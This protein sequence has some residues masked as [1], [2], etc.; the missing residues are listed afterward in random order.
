MS[1][2]KKPIDYALEKAKKFHLNG[3]FVEED[4]CYKKIHSSY[5]NDYNLLNK[6]L[7]FQMTMSLWKP[8]LETISI[9]KKII[10]PSVTVT[11]TLETGVDVVTNLIRNEAFVNGNLKNYSL[12]IELLKT[13]LGRDNTDS[14]FYDDLVKNYNDSGS[15]D[16]GIDYFH[17]ELLSD[18]TNPNIYYSLASLYYYKLA[19]SGSMDNFDSILKYSELGE[20][21]DPFNSSNLNVLG[22]SYHLVGN[23]DK[24]E[25]YF[26]EAIKADPKSF[27]PHNNLA[28]LYARNLIDQS[29]DESKVKHEYTPANSTVMEKALYHANA[30]LKIDPKNEATLSMMGNFLLNSKHYSK[31]I[32]FFKSN[33]GWSSQL[34]LVKCYYL[35]EDYDNFYLALNKASSMPE[36][37]ESRELSALLSHANIHLSSSNDNF[38]CPEPLD[39][40]HYLD[41]PSLDNNPN[42]N[43]RLLVVLNSMDQG[44][45]TQDL[46]SN[47]EQSTIN[48]F[49]SDSEL[50]E[51]FKNFLLKAAIEYRNKYKNC[52]V[53]FIKRWPK[54]FSMDGWVVNMEKGGSLKAHNH[55]NGWLSGV[56]YL[57]VPKKNNKNEGNIN[58]SLLDRDYPQSDATF[59]SLLI[60]T[61]DS[62]LVLFP[63]SLYHET[64]PFF[65]DSKRICIAFDFQPV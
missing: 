9:I 49:N 2:Q 6:L 3:N 62:R 10:I 57:Q 22:M 39:F 64:V 11:Q 14:N 24:S 54:N 13:S 8:S 16:V 50:I 26:L 56:Y 27:S 36:F 38:Y 45:R 60:N 43:Q 33:D 59:P 42:F 25:Y 28:H 30:S 1:K 41:V 65:D 44:N 21:Y 34:G 15:S 53:E 40:V 19:K 37:K 52:N 55:P 12:A 4:A 46:L 58:F 61:E 5:P 31:A 29:P 7:V 35:S 48:F 47:G 23:P 17:K 51:I 20:K 63:S 18:K 32:S